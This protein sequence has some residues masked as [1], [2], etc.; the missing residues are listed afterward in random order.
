MKLDK[1]QPFAQIVESDPRKL[2]EDPTRYIQ[3][4]IRFDAKGN[5]VDEKEVQEYR[6][7]VAAS[8]QA[9]AD[10]AMEE[11]RKV[12]EQADAEV[13]AL[14][15]AIEASAPANPNTVAE[16]K[17]ALTAKG[18]EYPADAKKADLQALWDAA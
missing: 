9:K 14:D 18:I 1:R 8:A 5:P 10:A 11:A 12:Q 3:N 7:S 15:A 6:N 17:E 2:K 16:L 4:G 13:A